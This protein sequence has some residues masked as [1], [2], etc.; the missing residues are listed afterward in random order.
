LILAHLRL[1][2]LLA[3]PMQGG[4]FIVW[5]TASLNYSQSTRTL[6]VPLYLTIRQAQVQP[7]TRSLLRIDLSI[8]PDFCWDDKVHGT[9]KTF[10]IKMLAERL[11]CFMAPSCCVSDVEKM[12]LTVPMFKPVPP[13][14]YISVV[15]DHWLHV[16]TCLPI[17]FKHLILPEKFPPPTPLLNLQSL[18]LSALHHKE[19]PLRQFKL[20]T[21]F[22]HKSFRPCTECVHCG[23][24]AEG[25]KM[26]HWRYWCR[27]SPPRER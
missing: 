6:F 7:I 18:P 16:E 23:V 14:Y 21:K 26:S 8:A 12:T 25:R 19:F 5:S 3:F 27:S 13:N 10:L 15:S 24:V 22:R 1:E 4:W 2:S 11:S 9:A 17:S 20:L